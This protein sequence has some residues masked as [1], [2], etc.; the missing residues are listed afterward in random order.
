[1]KKRCAILVLTLLVAT[2]GL[3]KQGKGDPAL[4]DN[5]APAAT[6]N[7]I[8]D[9]T[10]YVIGESDVL[11]INVWHE[12]EVSRV[13]PVRAD[14]K[15]SLPLIGELTASGLTPARLQ[16]AITEKLQVLMSNPEV[17]VIVQDAR[18]HYFTVVGEVPRPGSYPLGSRVTVLDA[19][20]LAGGLKDFAKPKKIYVLRPQPDG[21]S[22]K[23][24]FNYKRALSG[25]AKENIQLLARDTIVVP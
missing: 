4:A 11:A 17:T 23:L 5:N 19:I 22:E 16:A 3:A 13:L 15:I 2:A 8:A 10:N 12:P 25:D 9:N 14:G 18:S 24:P 20:A 6:R 1:M 21:S 7:D